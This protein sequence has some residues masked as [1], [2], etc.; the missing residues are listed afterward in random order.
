MDR[1]FFNLIYMVKNCVLT[2]MNESHC[3][4]LSPKGKERNKR[5]NVPN[6]VFPLPRVRPH[7]LDIYFDLV[8]EVKQS[9]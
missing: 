2:H 1:V 4:V 6:V 7:L 8:S 9:N 5:E 3:P